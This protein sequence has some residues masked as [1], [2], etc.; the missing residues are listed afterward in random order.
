M[1]PAKL[2]ISLWLVA[3]FLVLLVGL[4]GYFTLSGA[5]VML[6]FTLAFVSGSAVPFFNKNYKSNDRAFIRVSVL[7]NLNKIAWSS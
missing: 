7:K 6:Y 4:G 2:F 3:I 5:L 1:P